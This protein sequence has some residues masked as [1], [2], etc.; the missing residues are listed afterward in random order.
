[1][2]TPTL[3]TVILASAATALLAPVSPARAQ[4]VGEAFELTEVGSFPAPAWLDA[5]LIDPKEP[6]PPDPSV[7]VVETTNARGTATRGLALEDALAPSQGI[8]RFIRPTSRYSLAT[9]VRIDRY[10]DNSGGTTN[11]WPM[12]VGVGQY[13]DGVDLAFIATVGVYASS[14]TGEWHMYAFGA[15]GNAFNVDYGVP[16]EVGAWYRVEVDFDGENGVLHARIRDLATDA[17]VVDRTD[18]FPKW[19][20]EDA[21]FDTAMFI[22]GEL[23]PET[24]IA[25]LAVID[26]ICVTPT[27]FC[28]ADV[29]QDGTVDFADLL[30]VL[31][32]WGPCEGPCGADVDRSGQVDFADVLIV[33][34][35]WGP[36]R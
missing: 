27:P 21:P 36:C 15:T 31:A 24:T 29:D 18:A 34:S 33:L 22:D 2:K 3:S 9:D 28:P 5:G 32:E 30:M 17:L 11:D 10:S 12:Y 7:T 26:N 19:T 16:A 23:T 1:M 20:P 8:Y 25:N 14:L 35:S 4:M 13:V 6:N